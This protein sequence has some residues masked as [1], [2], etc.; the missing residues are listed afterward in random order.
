MHH[1]LE[2][3]Y[4]YKV[5]IIKMFCDLMD[6]KSNEEHMELLKSG[7]KASKRLI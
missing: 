3:T 4:A 1:Y 5:L 6:R 2:H 7:F